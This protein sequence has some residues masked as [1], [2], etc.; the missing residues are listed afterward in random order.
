MEKN[1]MTKKAIFPQTLEIGMKVTAVCMG[2]EVGNYVVT[3]VT[4]HMVTLKVE[5]GQDD[6]IIF[7]DRKV[8][9]NGLVT[10]NV[11]GVKIQATDYFVQ[12]YDNYVRS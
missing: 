6:R 8:G 3:E 5:N 1:Q 4:P 9:E 7:A 11:G 12:S 10:V 2:R